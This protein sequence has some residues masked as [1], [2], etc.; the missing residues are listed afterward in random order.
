MPYKH[1]EIE[2]CQFAKREG[3]LNGDV[4]ASE[5][6]REATTLVICDGLGSGVR[7]NLAA[8]F[9]ARRLLELTRHGHSVRA[10][11]RNVVQTMHQAKTSDLPYAAFCLVHILNDGKVSLLN[12]EMPAP[13]FVENAYASLP[14]ARTFVV[15]REVVSE[16]HFFLE[17]GRR[18]FLVSDGVTQAGMGGGALPLG[19]TDAG[20]VKFVNKCFQLDYG[21]ETIGARILEQVRTLDGRTFHDDATVVSLSARDGN[22]VNVLSGPPLERADDAAV[23]RRFMQTDGIKIICGSTTATIASRQLETELKVEAA[24]PGFLEPPRYR[25]AGFEVVTEGAITLNQVFNLLD[26]NIEP[27]NDPHGVMTIYSLLKF[28]DR[29]NFTV[30][31]AENPAHKDLRF[32]QLGVMPRAKVIPL[33]A[34]RLREQGKLVV[35]EDV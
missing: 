12:Y 3:A 25:L 2:T 33:I 4:V 21:P 5:R 35:L 30:G 14:A 22:V 16:A 29:V 7:A 34:E 23:I 13:I 17:R 27:T 26:G 20:V 19:W 1:I 11:F 18:I 9:A 28:A 6:T 10:A 24:P 31:R 8:N 15:G 32:N